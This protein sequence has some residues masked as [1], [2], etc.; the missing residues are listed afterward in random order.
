MPAEFRK[1]SAAAAFCATGSGRGASG[2]RH[3]DPESAPRII[4]ISRPRAALLSGAGIRPRIEAGW[5]PHPLA[6]A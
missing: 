1:S 2:A 3:D 4:F 6:G 5:D